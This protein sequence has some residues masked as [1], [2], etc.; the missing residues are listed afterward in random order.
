MKVC[1]IQMVWKNLLTWYGEHN[2]YIVVRDKIY[3]YAG[4]QKQFFTICEMLK[5][6]LLW[7]CNMSCHP[8]QSNPPWN[9]WGRQIEKILKQGGQG[10]EC[11]HMNMLLR[12]ES[13]DT[14]WLLMFTSWHSP[15]GNPP[16]TVDGNR[17]RKSWNRVDR[18][19]FHTCACSEDRQWWQILITYGYIMTPQPHLPWVIGWD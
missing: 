1:L 17:Q 6:F 4:Y 9:C 8:P 10:V 18:D 13:G 5:A 2:T 14:P 15:Q 3:S 12:A 11:S 19:I 7:I 16:G